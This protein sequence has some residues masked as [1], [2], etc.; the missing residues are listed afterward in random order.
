MVID[1]R[2]GAQK[3]CHSAAAGGTEALN[4]NEI[5][6]RPHQ[7]LANKRLLQLRRQGAC[8][9][10]PEQL[11]RPSE[12]FWTFQSVVHRD[13]AR[14]IETGRR[15]PLDFKASKEGTASGRWRAAAVYYTFRQVTAR[16]SKV[17]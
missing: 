8:A 14:H 6:A 2:I 1:G 9:L 17:V 4:D 10:A 13:T 15:P 7:R 12:L 3:R 5:Q 11:T 16:E